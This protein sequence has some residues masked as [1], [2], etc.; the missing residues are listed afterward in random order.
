MVT[1]G[2]LLVRLAEEN[3]QVGLALVLSP[4]LA[5]LYAIGRAVA[6]SAATYMIDHIIY[7]NLLVFVEVYPVFIFCI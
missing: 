4:H 2:Y 1:K 7:G 5:V 3:P 6:P